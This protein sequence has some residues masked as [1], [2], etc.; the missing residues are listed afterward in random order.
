MP[1]RKW[2]ARRGWAV[3]V[4]LLVAL[5]MLLGGCGTLQVGMEETPSP[6]ATDVV[7]TSTLVAETAT[8]VAPTSTAILTTDTPVPPTATAP[9]SAE[10][11]TAIPTATAPP[12]AT[13]LPATATPPP[14]PGSALP[15]DNR[16]T[17]FGVLAS[18]YNAINRGEYER[19]YGYLRNPQQDYE[20]FATGFG[21]TAGAL[22]AAHAPYYGGAAAGSQYAAMPLLLL[23]TQDDGSQEY[24][25]G[26]AVAWRGMVSDDAG[27]PPAE[28]WLDSFAI[29]ATSGP[30]EAATLREQCRE[31]EFETAQRPFDLRDGPVNLLGS[32]YN[33]ISRGEYERAYG[34]WETAP[35]PFESFAEGFAETTDVFL[36]V[37]LP[38]HSD[39]AAGSVFAQVPVL[40]LAEQA[41]GSQQTFTGCFVARRANPDAAGTETEWA[42]REATI[43]QSNGTDVAVLLDVC[44]SS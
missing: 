42:L 38:Y 9:G 16:Q 5:A 41:D 37:G 12:T 17:A 31:H 34:Y 33:A 8:P 43:T 18:Y 21:E 27:P 3:Y 22:V 40:L 26:C 25:A 6:A 10:T 44:E 28:W 14:A 2:F 30:L 24:Y 15:F 32:Y 11:A 13:V 35:Q 1:A 7:S 39:A 23:A 36:V 19:A 20:S 29:E 4:M